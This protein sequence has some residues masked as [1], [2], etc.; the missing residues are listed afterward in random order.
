[1]KQISW[2]VLD[3][4]MESDGNTDSVCAEAQK[5]DAASDLCTQKI[6]EVLPAKVSLKFYY[7]E[8]SKL[9]VL[10]RGGSDSLLVAKTPD[11]LYLVDCSQQKLLSPGI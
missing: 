3:K 1:M 6:G 4:G 10:W 8:G 11:A 7:N 5:R 9:S 2:N